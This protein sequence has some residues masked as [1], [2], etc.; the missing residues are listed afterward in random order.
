MTTRV[1]GERI[2]RSEDG[3]LLTGHGQFLD[4]VRPA[5]CL[6]AA[7]VRAQFGHARIV[8]VDVTGALDV[9]GVVAIYTHEDLGA[10][11]KPLP[12]GI[13][14]PGLH[15][16]RTQLPLA[17]D[18]VYF[19]GQPIALVVAD[20]RAVAED[21]AE[22]VRVE[23]EQLPVVADVHTADAGEALVHN[24]VPGNVAAEL[25]DT[26][27]DPDAAFADAPN[28]IER[29]LWVE[30]GAAMPIETRGVVADYRPGTG[31]LTVW[32]STQSPNTIRLG[33]CGFFKLPEHKV[34]VIAPDVGGGFGV[35]IAYWYPEELLIPFASLELGRPVKWVEDRREHFIGS[36]HERG[37][38]HHARIAFDDEGHILAME[39]TF[40]HDSGAFVPYG[41]I[42]PLVTMARLPGPYK[43]P[44]FRFA[45]KV[46]YTNTVP[47]TPYRGAGQPEAVFITERLVDAIASK[48][49]LDKAEVRR[50]NLIQHDEYPYEPGTIDEDGEPTRY[51]SGDLPA[52]LDKC[53]ELV[54]ATDVASDR[55]AAERR[56]KRLGIGFGAYVEIT[57][58]E[59][60]EGARVHVEPS[61]RVFVTTGVGTQ[62][63]GHKTVLAQVAAEMLGVAFED[64][65]VVTGDTRQFKWATGTFASRIAV[66]AGNAVAKAALSVRDKALPLAADM[67]E[68]SKDDLDLENGQVFVK[69]SPGANVSLAELA[70]VANPLRVA[71]D[72]AA[73]K[74]SQFAEKQVPAM[75][76][77][78]D[79]PGLEASGYFAPE[80]PT[81]ANGCHAAV[82]EVDPVT[83]EIDILRYAAVHD[84][85]K[86][87]NP[88]LLEGQM[89][90]GI[91]QGIGGAFYEKLH[92][93]ESGQL[94]NA[95]FMDYLIPYTTEIPEIATGH[96]ET[97][98]PLNPLGLKGAG[99]AGVMPPA[100][101]LAGAIE[102]ALGFEISESPLSPNR[103]FELSREAAGRA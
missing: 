4:D 54:R 91:A 53:L 81:Y 9:E 21:V 27:G 51:D 33:I 83:F 22:R 8:D 74:A 70:V 25:A 58:G 19:V 94:L 77:L 43:V 68:A 12:L 65:E 85:G 78:G 63:Q 93:D 37:Q 89:Y 56:G 95:S 24:D 97:P 5:G 87:I 2:K 34:E 52:V 17:R 48:L 59:L 99:E 28:V 11:D 42:V 36:H 79:E 102:D 29:T 72:E 38:L 67:L 96:V 66:I 32:D 20:D 103:L 40:L 23:Y 44:A 57:G 7:I 50:R 60:Y 62:G 92:Y 76:L 14:N 26:V 45:T 64:V 1:I 16:P 75:A 84:C 69:G 100:A 30:R 41:V 101:V 31:E 49:G 61:G 13:P 6:H 82:V 80:K 47:V 46:L 15:H 18:E 90:G 55:E 88:T 86:V 39:D 10:L 71:Y 98:S 35:K 3:P 73:L